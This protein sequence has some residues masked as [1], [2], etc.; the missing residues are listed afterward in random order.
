MYENISGYL[1]ITSY[2]IPF[3]TIPISVGGN[4]TIASGF[5]AGTY[6]VLEIDRAKVKLNKTTLIVEG[7]FDTPIS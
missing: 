4:L 6:K 2:E 3:D 7:N 1:W 5:N